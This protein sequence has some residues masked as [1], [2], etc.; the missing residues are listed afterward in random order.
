MVLL[1][2]IWTDNVLF[3]DVLRRFEPDN[4][5]YI[6]SIDWYLNLVR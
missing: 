1:E 4:V 5:T 3:I 2:D 6:E